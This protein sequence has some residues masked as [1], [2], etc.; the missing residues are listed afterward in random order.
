MTVLSLSSRSQLI[1]MAVGIAVKSSVPMTVMKESE[2][3]FMWVSDE[4]PLC[5]VVKSM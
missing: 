1:C 3:P 2:C 5:I 4:L